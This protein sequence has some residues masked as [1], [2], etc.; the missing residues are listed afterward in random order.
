MAVA[1]TQTDVLVVDDNVLVCRS[2]A[3]LLSLSGF[4]TRCVETGQ[5]ALEFLKAC[6]P[7]IV[8][9]DVMMPDVSGFD[10]LQAIRADARCLNVVVLMYSAVSDPAYKERARALGANDYL[11]KGELSFA[12]MKQLVAGHL[13][14]LKGGAKPGD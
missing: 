3:R 8:L 5:E 12:Q 2:L 10:V 14:R 7:S 13:G 6:R 4:P 1:E 11:V 9:L